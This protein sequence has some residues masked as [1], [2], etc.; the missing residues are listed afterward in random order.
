M[1]KTPFST[2]KLSGLISTYPV[3]VAFLM[4]S[5][6]VSSCNFPTSTIK[7]AS[8]P[9]T[10]AETSVPPLP[11][12]GEPVPPTI[13]ETLPLSQGE[14]TA[15][16]GIR[17]TFDQE[18]D[19]S[20]V[21]GALKLDPA[22]PGRFEW[23]DDFTVKFIPEQPF[24]PETEVNVT[25]DATARSKKGENLLRP[26]SYSFQSSGSLR[27]VERL[28]YSTGDPV[29]PS[30]QIVATFNRPVVTLGEDA[31]RLSPAFTITPVVAGS[32]KWLNT[33]TYVF[34]AEPALAGGVTYQVKVDSGLTA[35]DGAALEDTGN[36][37]W[38]FTTTLP[39][40]EEILP[41]ENSMILLDAEF[42]VT[43][44]QPMNHA[45]VEQNLSVLDAEG[46]Q[47]SGKYT[48]NDMGT[49]VIFT[50][51]GLLQRN[52]SVQF[53]MTPAR[54]LGGAVTDQ[55]FARIYSTIPGFAVLSTMPGEGE[56][57]ETYG[58][59]GGISLQLNAPL[60]KDQNLA[61][62]IK[63]NPKPA[64]LNIS[65]DFNQGMINISGV[66]LP[67]TTY[68]ITL[69]AQT[70]D[71]FGGTLGTDFIR[72][73]LVSN[74]QPSL[75]L[76]TLWTSGARLFATPEDHSVDVFVTNI[77][78][79]NITRST[80]TLADFLN[81]YVT[82]MDAVE[83]PAG[84]S[85][86][87][88]VELPPNT[89]TQ[90]AINLDPEG[91]TLAPGLYAFQINSPQLTDPI[92]AIKFHLVVSSIHLT[93]KESR[94]S[95][96][97][98]AVD[99]ATNQPLS[100]RTITLYNKNQESIGAATTD[101]D[102][103]AVIPLAANRTLY[104]EIVAVLGKPGED[105]FSL[106]TN[107]WSAGLSAWEFGLNTQVQS[108]DRLVYTY[109]DRPIY[110]PGQ[111]VYFRSILKSVEN[112]RY[113][114][115]EQT[116][117]EFKVYE[118]YQIETGQTRLLED[119]TL[120]ISAYGTTS[121]EFTLPD[122]AP[123]GSYSIVYNFN[124]TWASAVFT[125][126][127]YRKPEID[128]SVSF[129][130]QEF[131]RGQDIRAEISASYF[132]GE[133][134]ANV[135]VDW[136]LTA[137]KYY[138]YIPGY[139]IG[140]LDLTWLEP[141]AY[142]GI[143][144]MSGNTFLMNGTATTGADG[145][146][147]LTFSGNDLMDK[148]SIVDTRTLVLQVTL[149]DESLLPVSKQAEAR[150]HPADYY[151]GVKT[152]TW[153]APAG[154]PIRFEIQTVDWSM[155]P[156]GEKTLQASF[157][158][159]EWNPVMR[160]GE[161]AFQETLT[162]VSGSDFQTDA[163]GN[164]SLEFTP[165]TPGNYRLQISDGKGAVTQYLLWVHGSGQANWPASPDQHI[166][167][168]VDREEYSVGETAQLFVPNPFGGGA[169]GLLTIER[170]KV[171]SSQV[172]HM[173]DSSTI[174]E[175]PI[176]AEDAP[177]IFASVTLLGKPSSGKLELRQ[178]YTEIKVNPQGLLLQLEVTPQ[179]AAYEPGQTAR[180]DVLV[181]DSLGKPVQGEF[182][183]A[184][185]DKAIYALKESNAINIG[186]AF[187][188]PQPL[189]V[190]TDSSLSA[191]LNRFTYQSP[192]LGGGGGGEES[193]A[194]PVLRN[195]FKDTAFWQGAFETD[196]Q[197][198]AEIEFALP[199]NLTTWVITVRGI[200]RDNL[201]GEAD[202][203]VQVTKDLIISPA[204]PRFLVVGD[205]VQL[206]AV[207]YN[208][209]SSEL[210]VAVDFQAQ[211]VNFDQPEQA[212]QTV[213]VASGE[214]Q[215][216]NWWVT[217]QD[218]GY[219]SLRFNATA[220][221][222]QDASTPPW[223]DI[224]IYRYAS[225]Q[226]FA[227]SGVLN[228]AGD[229]LEVV[230]LPRSFHATGGELTVE[231]TPTLAG[232]LIS[233]LNALE[234]TPGGMIEPMLSRLLA[235]LSAFNL[236]HQSGM[237]SPDLNTRLQTEIRADLGRLID[238][239]KAEGGWGWSNQDSSDIYMNTYAVLVLHMAQA[240]DFQVD[241]TLIDTVTGMIQTDLYSV[242]MDTPSWKL[243]RLAF[244]FYALNQAGVESGIP[245]DLMSQRARL[246]PWAQALVAL[247]V[248]PGDPQLAK[249]IL[250]DL[251]SSAVRSST[252]AHWSDAE[253]TYWNFSST[254]SNTAMVIY[255]LAEVDPASLLMADALRYVLSNRRAGAGWSSSYDTGWILAAISKAIM[256]T[257]EL[258]SD[259]KY[260][261]VINGVPL[262]SGEAQGFDS[263]TS[264]RSRVALNQLAESGNLLEFS[265]TTGLGRLYYRA[266]L[267]VG[268]PVENALPVSNGLNVERQYFLESAD[269]LPEDCQAIHQADLNAGNPV[270][271]VMVT[272][273]VPE[274]S[275]Y[276][277]VEDNIPAGA[278]IVDTQLNTAAA[279]SMY[280]PTSLADV[281]EPMA[282][283]WGRW[284]FSQ[285]AISRSQIRWSSSF[286]PAGT[287][288]L[289]YRIQLIQ[290]GEYRVLPARAYQYY[291]PE[292]EGRSAGEVFTIQ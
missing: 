125:V 17:L 209:T 38:S 72:S 221:T 263:I 201:V 204:T 268:Q 177:N 114:P 291:F 31:E 179:T 249:T 116:D 154:S 91:G 33:S 45:D 162:P 160:V 246:N 2:L 24:P 15:S 261:A 247:T 20:S 120:S 292:V 119:L 269:C 258:Q 190:L 242:S 181:T 103:L 100:G 117:A 89:N 134:A 226:T 5:L 203:E 48:W 46:K 71:R 78:D 122:D 215:R 288:T 185:V 157:D 59:F 280:D 265:R 142:R 22:Y 50:P 118:A 36:L 21:E 150:L 115:L 216:V 141:A 256:A 1:Q 62:L 255:A 9:A 63:V 180:F 170:G 65:G 4:I 208:N 28:P 187:Y 287:Y 97:V 29:D 54:G 16:G 220:G 51:A 109:T 30:S 8:T 143:Y 10:P 224:P 80:I 272:I 39:K 128:L 281:I 140:L 286:V 275:Y 270:V 245:S 197:G 182:S 282:K 55:G 253:R 23:S 25:V 137:Q 240:A 271:E 13:V 92:Y 18:M 228:E 35:L 75:N 149:R 40:V 260:S 32:G 111:T 104:E 161:S 69:P 225:P 64:V 56:P 105:E 26:I 96:L 290:A 175:I 151:I 244:A 37:E 202:V 52:S 82:G 58:D 276:L 205:H 200:T 231:M 169:L 77:R 112:S 129:I 184:A 219:A 101:Q 218:A 171:M 277:V 110:Q 164:A 196:T 278:E 93:L 57:L 90:A 155:K 283:G 191:Y 123:P 156:V 102:G 236:M 44:N 66:Y 207:V 254:L 136:V 262:A 34:S 95:M 212:A 145:R 186:T 88:T 61:A 174:V 148:L 127:D 14:L 106:A 133:V 108:E 178:G 74:S 248:Q 27:L 243:D 284:F 183:F 167:I 146:L 47:I 273:T 159:I 42:Q 210:D 222:L 158:Q 274:D 139:S 152:D 166:K 76:P 188:G 67:N 189:A 144:S 11:T 153:D 217:V 211:G 251:A 6:I 230:S 163:S 232:L 107:Q 99:M 199:D 121:G 43:F 19:H 168:E 266:N 94:D 238:S 206:G 227:T 289:T 214:R 132:S 239:Q 241:Q 73:F 113:F 68:T 83:F 126:A 259:F 135:S 138:P 193:S 86:S 147:P 130:P 285:P 237:Q 60:S 173:E 131:K 12:L 79:I 41:P 229:T 87:Q 194:N 223:G 70:A 81:S 233:G 252:G 279:I 192:G 250:S 49:Q 172:I 85:W 98:W 264:T 165:D 124:D 84:Q 176:T 235:N 53:K 213:T 3:F 267:E 257:G 234:S 195:D 198:K 7:S